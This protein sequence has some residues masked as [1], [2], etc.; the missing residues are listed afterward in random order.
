VGRARAHR[1]ET[2]MTRRV[3]IVDDEPIVIA[4]LRDCFTSFQHGQVYEITAA[5]SGQEQDEQYL[6]VACI[7]RAGLRSHI[8]GASAM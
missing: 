4:L 1:G 2:D 3:L 6:C 7:R 8:G 5:H